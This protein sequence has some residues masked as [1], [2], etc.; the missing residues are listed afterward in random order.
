MPKEGLEPSHPKAQ[1]PKSCVSANSTTP[2]QLIASLAALARR[3]SRLEPRLLRRRS[4][5]KSVSAHS[6]SAR[7]GAFRGALVS[8]RL[9]RRSS[10][11]MEVSL[12]LVDVTS[13]LHVV[14]R[15]RDGAVALLV[16]VDNKG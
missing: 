2:A 9:A 15:N 11:Q 5:T 3:G 7:R 13:G 12:Q 4:P 6:F 16:D 1:E 10:L 8:L 14:L